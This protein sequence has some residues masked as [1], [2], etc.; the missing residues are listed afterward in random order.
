MTETVDRTASCGVGLRLLGAA[1]AVP[2]FLVGAVWGGSSA[3]ASEGLT[4]DQK[5]DEGCTYQ[6]EYYPSGKI[7]SKVGYM[8]S[9]GGQQTLGCKT[10]VYYENGKVAMEQAFRDGIPHGVYRTFYE[11]GKVE[12]EYSYDYGTPNGPVTY[13][14]SNG[15]LKAQGTMREGVKDGHW[16][17]WHEDGAVESEGDYALGRK[18]GVWTY[19]KADGVTTKVVDYATATETH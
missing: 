2:F 16:T 4:A 7:K 9:S 6:I 3:V 12:M 10:T 1:M 19:H 8:T 11:N 5:A 18:V 15:K 14:Y 13:W 17:T